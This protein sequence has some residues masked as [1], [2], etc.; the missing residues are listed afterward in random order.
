MNAK[1]ADG[2]VSFFLDQEFVRF[3]CSDIDIENEPIFSS[4]DELVWPV[5]E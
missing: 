5:P 1:D 4:R 2:P 3:V